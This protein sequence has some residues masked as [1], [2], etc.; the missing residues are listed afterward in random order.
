[1][2]EAVM[3]ALFKVLEHEKCGMNDAKGL[4]ESK[5]ELHVRFPS[6]DLALLRICPSSTFEPEIHRYPRNRRTRKGFVRTLT[7]IQLSLI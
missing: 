5:S 3:H 6:I 7:E 2:R 1:M 4:K